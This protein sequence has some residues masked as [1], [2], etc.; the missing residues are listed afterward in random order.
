MPRKSVKLVS[1]EGFE[2][3]VDYRAACVSNTI[4]QMLSSEGNFTE[5]ELGEIN[6][7][8]IS[9]PILEKICEYFYYRLR[10]MNESSKTIP[11]FCIPPEMALE[12][13]KASN[14]LDT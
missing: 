11:E 5:T 3:T 7:P 2:F 1:A 10:H 14:Y 9:A 13:L 4:K 12:L 8:E 6:F